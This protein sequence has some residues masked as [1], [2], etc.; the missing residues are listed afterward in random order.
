[1]RCTTRGFDQA[2]VS[3]VEF[4][5][6][7]PIVAMLTFGMLTGGLLFHQQLSVTHA[8]REAARLGATSP[9]DQADTEAFLD[10]VAD[11]AVDSAGGELGPDVAGRY[12]CVAYVSSS[13]SVRRTES[14]SDG[15]SYSSS[16]CF[17]DDRGDEARVQVRLRRDGELNIVFQR[18]DVPVSSDALARHE[19]TRSGG[20]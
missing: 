20:G 19:V 14:G 3:M 6:V 7:L 4:A 16:S 13:V 17:A 18:W 2:G 8:A 9:F 5:L 15:P 11:R 1:M 12:I 10:A